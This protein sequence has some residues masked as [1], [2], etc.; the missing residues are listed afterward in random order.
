MGEKKMEC[1]CNKCDCNIIH[2]DIVDKAKK[3]M[4][5]ENVFKRLVNFHKLMGD[6]TRAKIL[7]LLTEN[8]MCVCDI[9]ATLKMTK[10]AVSHQLKILKEN[11]LIKNRKIGKEVRY[12]LK[13]DH[14][15]KVFEISLEH[16][17]ES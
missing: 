13:D 15:T 17:E 4:P 10:S 3:A 12:S 8:E 14:V 7:F 2:E 1:K 5:K 9:A 16:V 6:G 11:N